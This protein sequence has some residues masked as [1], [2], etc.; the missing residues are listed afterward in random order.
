MKTQS[1]MNLLKISLKIWKVEILS[2][3]IR[4]L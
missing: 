3:T 1:F 2:F 4:I